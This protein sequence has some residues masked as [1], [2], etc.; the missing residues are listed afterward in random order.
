MQK[1]RRYSESEI[2]QL[3]EILRNDG[4]VSVPTDTVYGVCARMDSLA[5]QENLRELKHRPETKAFPIMCSDLQ[6]I[7]SVAETDDRS[8]KLIQALM[9][10]PVTLILRKKKD[11]PEY[12]NGGM[13]TLAIR[14]A[15]SEAVRKL[16]SA[17]GCPLFM[18]SANQSGEPVCTSLDE[19][20]HSCQGLGGML[21]GSVTFGEASTIIDCT[22]EEIKI[23]RPGPIGMEEIESALRK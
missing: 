12:V 2:E 21:E 1:I 15:T 13:D 8:D 7:Q 11:I 5:A 14:M 4:T 18:T 9:P 22:R 19:I 20:E 23:L 6:Q 10:G 3:A 16:I 17:V